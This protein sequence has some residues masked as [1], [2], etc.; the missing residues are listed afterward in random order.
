MCCVTLKP[1]TGLQKQIFCCVLAAEPRVAVGER[2]AEPC[3]TVEEAKWSARA[4][5]LPSNASV[6]PLLRVSW[7]KWGSV[8]ACRCSVLC[9]TS[10]RRDLYIYIN[11]EDVSLTPKEGINLVF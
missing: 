10:S 5:L 11:M 9:I 3:V 8:H 6:E 2:K 1:S 7:H 4:A